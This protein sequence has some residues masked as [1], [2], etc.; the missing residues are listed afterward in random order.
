VSNQRRL[1]RGLEALLGRSLDEPST[2]G[3]AMES[4]F[5][6]EATASEAGMHSSM[7]RD[8]NGQLWLAVVS[9]D[10]NP[11][12]PRKEFD[13]VEIADLADSIREHG[14]IQPL[15]VRQNGERFELVAGERRLRA[16]QAAGWERV[17][18]MVRDVNEQQMAELAIVENIQRKDLNPIEKANCFAK[19]MQDYNC[20]QEELAA[21]IHVDRS[22]VGNL[23]RLLELPE[24]VK[25]LMVKGDI[26][27]GH[28]RALLPL[29]DQEQQIDFAYRIKAESLTVRAVETMVTDVMEVATNDYLDPMGSSSPAVAKKPKPTRSEQLAFLEQELK[30]AL[31]TNVSISQNA[32]GRGKLT[33]HFSDASEFER[34]RNTLMN[35]PSPMS[36]VE[37]QPLGYVA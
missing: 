34:L 10:A 13:E 15:V 23:V 4:G 1:G 33:I 21:R 14:V 27:Q 31:G 5:V 25:K 12:Q 18:V 35:G 20:T 17:P 9:I 29:G 26:S 36:T 7:D 37:M 30:T 6:A 24:Q 28:A 3:V 22:T 8:Y 19:Y 2:T 32:K 16:A 11:H